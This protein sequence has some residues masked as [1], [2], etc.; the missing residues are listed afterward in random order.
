MGAK[1][2]AGA[3]PD[4][5]SGKRRWIGMM[6]I[7]SIVAAVWIGQ[8]S[9]GD[10]A[11]VVVGETRAVAAP[12]VRTVVTH[13]GGVEAEELRAIV[14]EEMGRREDGCPA[15]AAGEEPVEEVMAPEVIVQS[16]EAAAIVARAIEAGRWTEEDR[17]RFAG[18]ARALPPPAL[19][20]LQRTLH[21][22]IN[23]GQVTPADGL[24]PFG[25]AGGES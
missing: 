21:V 1:K 20:E 2:F 12:G 7:L 19:V 17:R 23:R 22:A 24:P 15:V 13:V 9:G 14:R 6:W 16:E 8:R 25:F 11:R 3:R 10:E 5:M 4:V 18:A